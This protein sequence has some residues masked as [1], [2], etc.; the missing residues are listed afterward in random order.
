MISDLQKDI[1]QQL[2]QNKPL[3]NTIKQVFN[4]EIEKNCPK[5]NEVD[6]DIVLGQKY[7]AYMEAKHI[8]R[9]CFREIETYEMERNQKE[10]YNKA[11]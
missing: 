11:R 9:E 2:L 6:D 3:L 1:L 8:I 5:V 7:R 10:N 4:E